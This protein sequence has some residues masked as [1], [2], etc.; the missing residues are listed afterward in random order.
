MRS[1]VCHALCQG[2]AC[3]GVSCGGQVG[4]DG[5]RG[6]CMVPHRVLD[7]A[8]RHARLQAEGWQSYGAGCGPRR[9]Y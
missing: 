3:P 4:V 5:G 8:Q 9:A 2:I 6:G 7:E 1:E